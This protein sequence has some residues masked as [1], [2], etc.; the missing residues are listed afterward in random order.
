MSRR[1]LK[2]EWKK[3]REGRRLDW[4]YGF[5]C[6]NP[7]SHG[8]IHGLTVPCGT[9]VTVGLS[10]FHALRK[11][12]PPMWIGIDGSTEPPVSVITRIDLENK[13]VYMEHVLPPVIP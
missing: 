9:P 11:N 13:A 7:G 2:K 4:P 1:K 12:Y 6:D 8:W 10:G 3:F 5:K